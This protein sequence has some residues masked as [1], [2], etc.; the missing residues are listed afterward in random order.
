MR[1]LEIAEAELGPDAAVLADL[2]SGLAITFKYSGRF[3]EAELCSREM[4]EA[5]AEAGD[6]YSIAAAQ[7]ARCTL[8]IATAVGVAA[9]LAPLETLLGAVKAAGALA[10]SQFVETLLGRARFV[11]ADTRRPGSSFG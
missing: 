6:V 1:G 10:V 3:D 8:A 4:V 11:N 5:A 7:M 9:A 2:L